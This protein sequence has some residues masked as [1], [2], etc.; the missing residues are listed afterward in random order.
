MHGQPRGCHRSVDR[1]TCRPGIEL[2]NNR[3]RS[4]DVVQ[5]G[6]RPH[7]RG[8]SRKSSSD[9]AQSETPRMHGNSTR[10]NRE[11]PSTLA[12]EGWSRVGQ[13]RPCA[14]RLI[15]TSVG[16]RT[17]AYYQRS[18]RTTTALRRRR[19]WREGDRP[20]R[21]PSKR[22]RPLGI[23]AVED[24]IVQHA[25]VTILNQI[26]EQD[27]V[28]FS[29]GFRPKRSQHHALDA[30]WVGIMRKQVSW[31]LDADIRDF[32]GSIDHGWMIKF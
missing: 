24:K 27:F 14:A 18:A 13:R 21:T 17:V 20:R 25:V 1:G 2:R 4:A 10:E 32:F 28:G 12:A 30:L 23:A 15:R 3:D 22:P 11:T 7:G 5:Q 26:Y 9:S 29:Y 8:R 16:S 6:G 19:A 31:V